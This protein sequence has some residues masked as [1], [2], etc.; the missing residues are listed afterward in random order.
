MA[1]RRQNLLARLV[2]TPDPSPNGAGGHYPPNRAA[3]GLVASATR[4]RVGTKAAE[5]TIKRREAWQSECWDAFDTVGEVKYGAGFFGNAMSRLGLYVGVIPDDP[6]ADPAPI[7]TDIPDEG[8]PGP[9][10]LDQGTYDRVTDALDRLSAGVGGR[11]EILREIAIN[12]SI[13][14]ECY[15]YGREE[16]GRPPGTNG[17]MDPGAEGEEVFD[18]RSIDEIRVE[19]DGKVLVYDDPEEVGKQGKGRTVGPDDF[20]V[21]IYQRHP[22]WS[23]RADSMLR[24]TLGAVEELLLTEQ[25][26]RA[27]ARSRLSAGLLLVPSEITFGSPTPSRGAEEEDDPFLAD[28]MEAMT[29]PIQDEGDASAVVPTVI[30][31]QADHLKEIRFVHPDRKMDEQVLQR[32]DAALKRIAQGMNLPVEVITGVA[33]VNHWTAWQ[34]EDS[35]FQAHIEPMAIMLVNAL[36][37]AFLLPMLEAAGVAD[38]RRFV[39]WYDPSRLITR[40][41]VAEAANSA[42]DRG[43]ISDDAYRRARGFADEDAPDVPDVDPAVDTA[44][45]LVTAAPSLIGDPGLPALVDQIRTVTGGAGA[46][47]PVDEADDG[48]E[49]EDAPI[50]EQPDGPDA[51]ARHA[52]LAPVLLADASRVPADLGRMLRDIDRDLRNRVEAAADA[53]MRRA[54]ERAGAR[55]RSKAKRQRAAHEA[56]GSVDNREVAATLG[57]AIVQSLGVEETDLLEDAFDPLEERFLGW[58]ATAGDATLDLIPDLPDEE[59]DLRARELAD[60]A[61][62]AWAWLRNALIERAKDLL[63]DPDPSPPEQGEWDEIAVVPYDLVREAVARAGGLAQAQVVTA[64]GGDAILD[65]A[66]STAVGIATGM[67]AERMLRDSGV[68]T[69]GWEWDYGPYHRSQ[70]FEPHVALDGTVFESFEDDALLNLDG[71]PPEPY[72]SPGDHPGCRCDVTPVMIDRRGDATAEVPRPTGAA[73]AEA[74]LDEGVLVPPPEAPKV[75]LRRHPAGG[76]THVDESGEGFYVR[77]LPTNEGRPGPWRIEEQFLDPDGA[78]RAVR[79]GESRTLDEVRRILGARLG[80][81]E[82]ERIGQGVR[83]YLTGG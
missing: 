68:Q 81:E 77:Q 48:E 36:T 35:T 21:R 15:L 23:S 22:R 61:R 51:A 80:G 54:L 69:E 62:D 44:L 39:V 2:G 43:V 37:E 7:T 66:T 20:L 57:P 24:G 78:L 75:S 1:D 11:A 73:E 71:W 65:A 79:I 13:A 74:A 4:L 70:G 72:Y 41:N 6:D 59:R 52:P 38:P 46:K 42:H 82:S 5:A 45:S 49:G 31:A 9:E 67:L 12:I 83:D 76:Y 50:P 8:E 16:G 33:D 47:F 34:I 64:D 27:T 18:V 25:A 32:Q 28:L 3:P 29:T 17:E 40:P 19:S 30:R 55:L 10:V 63:Y 58:C 60:H 53:Q 26:T 56:I 14:G